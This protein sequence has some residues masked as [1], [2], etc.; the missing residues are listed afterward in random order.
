VFFLLEWNVSL[1][2]SERYSHDDKAKGEL[3][4]VVTRVVA[5]L[6]WSQK[7]ETPK[8]LKV[9]LLEELTHFLYHICA[10]DVDPFDYRECVL[11]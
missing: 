1:P 9:S 2:T 6:H 4:W 3:L 5:R 7:Q 11:D 8:T 10:L